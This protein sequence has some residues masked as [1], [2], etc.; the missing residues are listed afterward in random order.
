MDDNLL[1]QNMAIVTA[2]GE[3][4]PYERVGMLAENFELGT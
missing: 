3:N 4:F 2:R 1:W